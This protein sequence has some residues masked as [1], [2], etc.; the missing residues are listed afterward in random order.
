MPITSRCNS[1]CKTCNVWKSHSNVDIEPNEL[2]NALQDPFFSDVTTV[3]INGGEFTLVPNFLEIVDAV[4]TLPQL[5]DIHCISNG[6]YPKRLFEY[7]EKANEK[8]NSKNVNLHICISVDGY[9]GV[10]EMVRG[11]QNCFSKTKM[12]LDTLYSDTSRY[13]HSFSVGCT[14]SIYNIDY[15]KE[16]ESFLSGYPGMRVE[17]HCAIPNKRIN[18]FDDADYYVLND[19]QKR[20]LAAEFFYEKFRISQDQHQRYQNFSN[21]YFLKNKGVGRLN[22]CSYRNRDVTI[23]ENL[24][25]SLCATASDIIGNLKKDSATDLIK[26][27]EYKQVLAD[28][29]KYCNRCGHYSYFPLTL[30]GRILYIREIMKIKYALDYY[31]L[32]TVCQFWK[33]QK[34]KWAFYRRYVKDYLLNFYYL[35]WKLQ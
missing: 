3:G 12:I 21:Y 6:L 31:S 10:H 22:V 9:G 35:I 17:Y 34:M 4:L 29:C 13:C 27:R 25:L 19:N 28:V 20:L 24:N 5:H 15:I 1:R 30:R 33:R 8:C 23:D 2:R 16:T 14:L 26:S 18:T 11:V 7:L 32:F